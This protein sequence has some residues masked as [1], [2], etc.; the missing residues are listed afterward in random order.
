M[1]Q[2]RTYLRQTIRQCQSL[3][4]LCR[5]SYAT[6]LGTEL[7]PETAAISPDSSDSEAKNV[8]HGDEEV[9]LRRYKPRTPG[10]R[11]LIRPI[12]DHL[13]MGR[14]YLPLTFPRKGHHIGGRN[15]TG[16]ITCRHRGGGH[17]R[18]IRTI[19]FDR[20]EAGKHRV[21]RIE[22][23]P[24]RS[25][26]IALLSRPK[27]KEGKNAQH[28]KAVGHGVTQ[29]SQIHSAHSDGITRTK[30]ADLPRDRYYSYIVAPQGMR[31]GELVESF[32]Q[33]VPEEILREL[34]DSADA[35]MIASKT[36]WRGNCLPL[37]MIPTG[38]IIYNIGL[39]ANK[40]AQLCRSAGTYGVVVNKNDE[41]EK[42]ARYVNVKL[43][44]GEVRRI[45]RD[46]CATI[47]ISSNKHHNKAQ[48][49]K[50]GRSRWLGI[51]PT[52]RGVAMNACDHPHGGGRGK[53]K[54]NVHPVSIWGQPVR[55]STWCIVFVPPADS[56]PDEEWIQDAKTQ[57]G[58]PVRSVSSTAY[59][60]KEIQTG[61]EEKQLMV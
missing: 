51:R 3:Q 10:V 4:Y 49:G 38:T 37:Y 53:S 24:G 31:T 13:Y 21:E 61:C 43:Q 50:A 29:V 1:L 55:I 12:N 17:K 7:A 47:G 14:P 5:R 9:R 19:D 52:V 41:T 27:P 26:H 8:Y 6:E 15:H 25:A 20:I 56:L 2:P 60:G 39:Y 23:D 54:G 48:L 18:R 35:G 42:S 57:E 11:H 36:A 44:S 58:E 33:G 30:D 22:Y 28:Q 34:G 59:A 40:G 46:A 32:R 45:T 16:T